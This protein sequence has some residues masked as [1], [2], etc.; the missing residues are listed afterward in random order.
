MS[1]PLT[2]RPHIRDGDHG[3]IVNVRVRVLVGVGVGCSAATVPAAA[4]TATAVNAHVHPFMSASYVTALFSAMSSGWD[5]AAITSR[6]PLETA[7]KS[8]TVEQR[9]LMDTAHSRR[10]KSFLECSWW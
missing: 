8:R 7:V 3:V 5:T 9:L 2:H 6:P 1:A 4:R 10:G